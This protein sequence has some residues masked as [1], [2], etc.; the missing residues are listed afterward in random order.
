MTYNLET[1][2]RLAAHRG[3]TRR[4][5]IVGA[6]AALSAL[7]LS[8][9][10][11]QPQNTTGLGS[12]K[13]TA[14]DGKI[15]IIHT[16]DS[17]GHDAAGAATSSQGANFSMAAVA[18]LRKDYQ[19]KGYWTLVLDAG[20]A[21]QD[22][23]LVDLSQGATAIDF[24]NAS[25]Y[26]AMALGNHEFDWGIDNARALKKRANFPLLSANVLDESGAAAF[27]ENAVFTTDNGANV[28]VFALT[29]PETYTTVNPNNVKGITFLAGDEMYAC[30]KKQVDYL[31]AQGC[32]LIICLAHLG[33]MGSSDPNRSAD[34]LKNVA[35]IDLLIDGHDHLVANATANGTLLVETGC[36]LQNIGVVTFEDGVLSERLIAAGT[37]DGNDA[38]VQAI[39]DAAAAD[40]DQQMSLVI[41]ATSVDLD[42]SRSPGVRTNETNLGDLVCDAALADARKVA[43]NGDV[44]GAIMNG[45][46]IR[47]SIAAGPI[48]LGAVRNTLPYDNMVAIVQITGAQLL[49][50]LEASTFQTPQAM[51][52]FP[53]VSGITFTV[54]TAVPWEEGAAY[55]N[56]TYHAPAKPGSRVTITDVGGK[57]FA[58]DARYTIATNDFIAAGGD[59]YYAFKSAVSASG[60]TYGS[61]INQALNDFLVDTL[62]GTVP[63]SY[64]KPK[65]LI[66]IK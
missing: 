26:A 40:V 55:P 65:G 24:M 62:G 46:A 15:A 36:W 42:G 14:I 31:K 35:G 30:A 17:H 39:I 23:V 20:D 47:A 4:S 57:G 3:L 44:D 38:T 10:S 60:C 53:Q 18:Q 19:D 7:G 50:A 48:T 29:T 64:A 54:N 6:T 12:A 59:T 32:Q 63:D 11:G 56:S 25:G 13:A 66:T 43:A 1:E 28:G 45:G 9:C 22:T 21:T 33:W 34:V 2:S 16:N 8:A 5:F 51:G 61:F 37:Y 41:G 49:E 27:S 58:A 52:S